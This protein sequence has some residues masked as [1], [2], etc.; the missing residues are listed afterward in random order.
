MY[1][2]IFP[3]NVVN[4]VSMDVML[5]PDHGAPAG[6]PLRGGEPRLVPAPRPLQP[7]GGPAQNQHS[8]RRVSG[9]IVLH[10]RV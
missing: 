8:R 2:I 10:G 5:Q 3:Q 1:T 7:P 6:D 4:I 9:Y